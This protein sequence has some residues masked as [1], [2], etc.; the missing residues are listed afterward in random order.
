MESRELRY[1]ISSWKQLPQCKSNNSR[2]LSIRVEELIQNDILTGTKISVVHTDFGVLFATVVDARGNILT[3]DYDDHIFTLLTDDILAELA[4]Y[5][6]VIQYKEEAL[7][8]KEQVDYLK[9]LQGLNFDKIRFISV[10]HKVDNID[11]SDTYIVCFN[12]EQ[13]PQWL[14]NTYNPS[15][16]EYMLALENGSVMNITNISQTY[17]YT[18]DWL[19][20]KVLSIDDIIE[21]QEDT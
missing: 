15:Y 1:R 12:I 11:T 2:D 4:K 8:S 13:N 17:H 10:N 14:H 7:L 6:F 19:Y 16:F 5:G 9:T 20:G 21:S 3:E 18:W